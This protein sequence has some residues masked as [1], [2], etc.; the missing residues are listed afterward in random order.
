MVAAERELRD[1]RCVFHRREYLGRRMGKAQVIELKFRRPFEV[2]MKWVGSTFTGR[3]LI[4]RSGWNGDRLRVRTSSPLVLTLDLDPHGSLA[5]R[6]SRHSIW[7][8]G[9]G[10]VIDALESDAALL[11]A[12]PELGPTWTDHGVVEVYG[13]AARC[14]TVQ[15]PKEREPRLYAHKAHI[16]MNLRTRLPAR[17]RIWD[18]ERGEIR[19]VEE[20]GWE[21]I[22][23]NPGLS[24]LDFD[25]DN[26]AYAF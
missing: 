2:Y 25:P 20:Y 1:L 23:L 24:D 5:M 8:S 26:P 11:Q 16:C 4:F 15:M 6:S 9:F 14:Y 7:W 21:G 3:E 17:V 10:R 18:E 12:R 19:L 13:E 22:E